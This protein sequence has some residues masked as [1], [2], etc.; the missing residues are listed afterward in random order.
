LGLILLERSETTAASLFCQQF[1]LTQFLLTTKLL[2]T[3]KGRPKRAKGQG[4]SGKGK[5]KGH[6]NRELKIAAK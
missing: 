4:Q 2:R 5:V 6:A 1:L 3:Q